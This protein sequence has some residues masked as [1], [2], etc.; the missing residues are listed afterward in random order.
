MAALR[1]LTTT[2]VRWAGH[3]NVPLPCAVTP[4]T[5][6][7]HWPC[8]VLHVTP[9]N[10]K[11]LTPGPGPVQSPNHTDVMSLRASFQWAAYRRRWLGTYLTPHRNNRPNTML[12]VAAIIRCVCPKRKW[13][14]SS[15]R[16][17]SWR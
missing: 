8:W 2:L 1:N 12:L 3:S 16:V 11:A 15:R 17:S 14:Q 9:E 13:R 7:K 6:P 4:L 5:S 10:E